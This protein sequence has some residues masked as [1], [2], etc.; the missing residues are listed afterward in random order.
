MAPIPQVNRLTGLSHDYINEFSGRIGFA[1]MPH[2]RHRLH[3]F[4]PIKKYGE[5]FDP[6]YYPE[7]LNILDH[8]HVKTLDEIVAE[9]NLRLE[10][11]D[12][13][14]FLALYPSV[15]TLV[16]GRSYPN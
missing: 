14:G 16:Y 13:E 1:N 9:M 4:G 7:V 11:R 2:K 15:H 8:P 6:N 3:D 5:Y 12:Y 10:Q